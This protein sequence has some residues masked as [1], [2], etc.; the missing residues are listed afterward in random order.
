[1]V[2]KAHFASTVL[3]RKINLT[4]SPPPV[5]VIVRNPFHAIVA[6][7]T[8]YL[9]SRVSR[10]WN[11]THT[12]SAVAPTEFGKCVRGR[13]KEKER[14]KGREIEREKEKERERKRKREKERKRKR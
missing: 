12:S 1:M 6:E 11:D 13:E 4:Q 5:I 14:K 2:V 8:R 3:L 7:R 9:R 10:Y